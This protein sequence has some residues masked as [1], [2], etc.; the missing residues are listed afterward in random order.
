MFDQDD[1]EEPPP[2]QK[3]FVAMAAA[4][5][6]QILPINSTSDEPP[7]DDEVLATLEK[8][9]LSESGGSPDAK[10][11]N[12]A[13]RIVGE[14]TSVTSPI[15]MK[16]SAPKGVCTPTPKRRRLRE[17]SHPSPELWSYSQTPMSSPRSKSECTSTASPDSALGADDKE[18]A[19]DALTGG[20]QMP[21][22]EWRKQYLM[23]YNVMRRF[24]YN[25]TEHHDLKALLKTKCPQT[26]KVAV[27]KQWTSKKLEEQA[28]LAE[29]AC[30]SGKLTELEKVV[31][32][33]RY[34]VQKTR[35]GRMGAFSDPE[36]GFFNASF[37][38]FTY[39]ADKWVFDRPSWMSKTV[40]EV[41]EM[42]KKDIEMKRAWAFI[43]KDM[44][45]FGLCHYNPKFGSAL[46]LCTDTF[47]TQS[48]LK[49]HLHICWK[50]LERQHIRDPAAFKVDGV[51]PVHVKQPPRDMLGPKARNV[52]PM[53]YYLQMPKI[54]GVFHD[55]TEKAF[56][57]YSVNAR[58]I[59]G[60]LQA[61]KI[62]VKA[63]S[64]ATVFL[65][66]SQ[67][68]SS[69]PYHPKAYKVDR[70]PT[71]PHNLGV[72]SDGARSTPPPNASLD[73]HT[74]TEMTPTPNIS[75]HRKAEVFK[76]R[77]FSL[78]PCCVQPNTSTENNRERILL[79]PES[80]SF[81]LSPKNS[82]RTHREQITVFSLQK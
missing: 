4:A 75:R 64:E 56:I 63:A 3:A 58:W 55:T 72:V 28:K 66:L 26:K 9:M 60:W 52:N 51:V 44:K 2:P 81:F 35:P 33:A 68:G 14:D 8:Q 39:H 57:D 12:D 67:C 78:L 65:L 59:T 50:W 17:K 11:G 42:C 34:L 21:V 10:V 5:S 30:N 47:K 24:F 7:N 13:A 15:G 40:E 16:S 77:T 19:S 82:P 70:S 1:Y 48:V 31:V 79:P 41:T 45:R 61:K 43:C 25:S 32:K 74:A 23:A 27:Y 71:Y 54:G 53:L 18:D 38:L 69:Q 73:T 62:T 29:I 76:K 36:K 37:G 20:F 6:S 80:P 49:L 46:E 22:D